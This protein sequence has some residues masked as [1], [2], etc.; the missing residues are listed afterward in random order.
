MLHSPLRE[1]LWWTESVGNDRNV[2][3]H[4]SIYLL[5]RILDKREKKK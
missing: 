1:S 2:I 3:Y 5:D 4:L